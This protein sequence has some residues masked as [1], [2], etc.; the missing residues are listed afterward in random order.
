MV[1]EVKG[2]CREIFSHKTHISNHLLR[3]TNKESVM[4]IKELS[5]I[6]TP[7]EV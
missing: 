3:I 2:N 6:T 5:D 1:R 7:Q 4:K